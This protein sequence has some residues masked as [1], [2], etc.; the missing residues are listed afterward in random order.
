MTTAVHLDGITKRFPGVI[1]NDDV[2]LTVERG[3]VHAL[4]GENGAGKTTLM[5]VLYGLYRP[6]EGRVVIE[7]TERKFSSPKDAIKAGVGMI[8]QHFMLVDPMTVTE[9]IVLGN[10]PRKWFG[11]AVDR[12]G[13]RRDV[14]ALS[15]RYGF[16]VDPEAT[17]ED[18]SVGVQQRVE[19]LKT[20][21]RGADILILDEPTAVLTPQEVEDLFDVLE[22]LTDQGKT[23]IFITHK[24]GEAMH[25]ADDVTVLRDGKNVGTVKTEDTTREQLAELMVGREVFLETDTNPMEPGDVVLSTN[26]LRAEDNRGMEAVSDVSFTVRE[27]EVFGIAG[28]DGNGQSELIESITGL[29]TPTDGSVTYLGSDITDAPRSDR[30]DAGMAYIPEDRHERGLV[31]DFDLVQNG[32][33]GSQHSK[34]FAERG[35]IDWGTT[36][37]HAEAI[38]DEYDVRPPNPDAN[39]ESLSGGN[40]QKFIAGREFERNPELV[41]ATHP[42]RGVDIGSTE[43]IH[44]RLLELRDSGKAVL[45]VSSKLDEVQGLSDRLAVMHDGEFMD[46]VDPDVVSEEEIGL[47]M[48]GEHPET[49][50]AAEASDAVA[51][52]G[53]GTDGGDQ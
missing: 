50:D 43:F 6:T 1:A 38:I 29:R 25:A 36:R 47:L 5:N 11:L 23:I 12:E 44:D 8:H 10:E 24:L 39:A 35:N 51:D 7:G 41:V 27:G 26:N 48:A 13:A 14:Q 17:I 9:N 31:M 33:L 37:R 16:D 2:D 40:Q 34:P 30:I 52:G 45:L 20:L 53:A 21:Y 42:T 18:V 19:I 15:D 3:T 4:L 28:V 49:A 32:I 22:E 46:V